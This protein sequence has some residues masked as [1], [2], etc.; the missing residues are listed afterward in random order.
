MGGI[1]QSIMLSAS[2]KSCVIFLFPDSRLRFLWQGC[3]R[4]P[5]RSD[6]T[7]RAASA[8][9]VPEAVNEA[10]LHPTTIPKPL[11]TPAQRA[12]GRG[13]TFQHLIGFA[14]SGWP[15]GRQARLPA[16]S[17]HPCTAPTAVSPERSL[18]H[19]GRGGEVCA[20]EEN[21]GMEG[22]CWDGG[23]TRA[24]VSEESKASRAFI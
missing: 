18:G 3:S 9:P 4:H 20:N 21:Q 7:P 13:G 2:L 24:G 23:A 11:L 12:V 14:A 19:T 8:T 16:L 22:V 6:A 1:K 17:F 10:W 5:D 15:K